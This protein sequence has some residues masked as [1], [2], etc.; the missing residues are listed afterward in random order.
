ME[1]RRPS[2]WTGLLD[3]Q[4]QNTQAA[5]ESHQKPLDVEDM[6]APPLPIYTDIYIIYKYINIC[7]Y[8]C[9]YEC[10]YEEKEDILYQ[11]DFPRSRT[12]V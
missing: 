10:M 4:A 2:G 7:I 8:I 11:E 9:T 12:R 3:I 5:V 6:E 1:K